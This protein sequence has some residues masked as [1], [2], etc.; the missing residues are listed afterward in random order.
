MWISKLKHEGLVSK[1]VAT[2][3]KFAFL[4]TAPQLVILEGI[5]KI[6][7]DPCI[8]KQ[9]NVLIMKQ[10]LEKPVVEKEQKEL[11]HRQANTRRKTCIFY[12]FLQL[13]LSCK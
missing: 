13:N 7:H 5:I 9:L 1:R 12:W 3:R 6:V 11:E 10:C 4:P 2:S 8:E